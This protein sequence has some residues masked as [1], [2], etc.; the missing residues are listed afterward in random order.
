MVALIIVS[1]IS[2]DDFVPPS[3][4]EVARYVAILIVNDAIDAQ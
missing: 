1:T 2:T 4:S 3:G